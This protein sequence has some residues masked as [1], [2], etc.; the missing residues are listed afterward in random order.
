MGNLENE[1]VIRTFNAKLSTNYK[2]TPMMV[3]ALQEFSHCVGGRV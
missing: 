3:V 1:T 2:N